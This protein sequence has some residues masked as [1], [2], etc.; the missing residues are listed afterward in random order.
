MDSYKSK[1]DGFEVEDIVRESFGLEEDSDLS[2][3]LNISYNDLIDFTKYII[4]ATM[5]SMTANIEELKKEDNKGTNLF[6]N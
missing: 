2:Q 5:D 1:I 4:G 6:L 3:G